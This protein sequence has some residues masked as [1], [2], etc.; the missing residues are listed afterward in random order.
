M[1][2]AL[3]VI[4]SFSL[5]DALPIFG[6]E[7]RVGLGEEDQLHAPAVL[8]PSL[9]PPFVSLG[10]RRVLYRPVQWA[11]ESCRPPMRG[12]PPRR[13]RPPL[14]RPRRQARSRP[15]ASCPA[16]SGARWAVPCSAAPC[17]GD[18]KSTR[19]NSSHLVIS[20]AVFCLKK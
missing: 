5:L 2:M 18:R 14:P 4:A 15:P 9:C 17:R 7:P 1:D 3:L 11:S 20:Y 8:C 6:C 12:R 19:L 16:S 13:S 10:F